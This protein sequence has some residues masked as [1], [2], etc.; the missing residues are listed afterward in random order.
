MIAQ[1]TQELLLAW[2]GV[3]LL[4]L[5]IWATS[6]SPTEKPNDYMGYRTSLSLKN[7]DTWK[8]AHKILNKYSQHSFILMIPF[9]PLSFYL[10]DSDEYKYAVVFVSG[11]IG[12]LYAIVRTEI[13]LS[14]I[15]F[16]NGKRKIKQE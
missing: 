3:Y 1:E 5:I 8:T 16:E 11:G 6:N 7:V 9:I 4:L 15:F 12:V 10:F 14:K 13:D 2:G